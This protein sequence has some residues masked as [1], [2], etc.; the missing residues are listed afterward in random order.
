M[1]GCHQNHQPSPGNRQHTQYSSLETHNICSHYISACL[2]LRNTLPHLQSPTGRS[3]INWHFKM[4]ERIRE[5]VHDLLAEFNIQVRHV[6]PFLH[7]LI[8]AL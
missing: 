6:G 8:V 5:T 4:R 2:Q 1:P 7:L 3:I